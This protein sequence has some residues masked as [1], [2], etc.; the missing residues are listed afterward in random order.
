MVLGTVFEVAFLPN[1][2][3]REG[4]LLHSVQE[5]WSCGMG[6]S[7]LPNDLCAIRKIN[8]RPRESPY[9]PWGGF[10]VPFG[11]QFINASRKNVLAYQSNCR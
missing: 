1:L 7:P 4:Q 10:V 3:S 6:M 9:D 2:S 11:V 5:E 8:P